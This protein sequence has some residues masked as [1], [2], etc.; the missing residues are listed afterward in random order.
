MRKRITLDPISKNA[1]WVVGG[2][3]LLV[4]LAGAAW[5]VTRM[6]PFGG[7][8][9]SWQSPQFKE[10]RFENTPP[11][12]TRLGLFETIENYWKGTERTPKGEIPIERVEFPSRSEDIIRPGLRA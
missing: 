6:E 9:G 3:A 4:L 8:P 10:G 1:K 5:L 2:L 12:D 11:Q 7:D